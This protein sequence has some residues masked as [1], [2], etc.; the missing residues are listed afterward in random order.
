MTGLDEHRILYGIRRIRYDVAAVIL[1]LCL[2]VS[3][4]FLAIMGLTEIGADPEE[5]AYYLPTI[6]FFAATTAAIALLVVLLFR[7]HSHL[8][9][10]PIIESS[11]RGEYEKAT[12]SMCKICGRH[13]TSKK[14]HIRKI[15]LLKAGAITSYFENCGCKYCLKPIPDMVGV[16]V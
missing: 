7:Y 4:L 8:Y 1:V 6:E 12:P 16:G 13:P 5:A 11:S 2:T 3:T 15:H 14:Y 10:D 9:H